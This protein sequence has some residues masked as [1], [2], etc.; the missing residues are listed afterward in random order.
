MYQMTTYISEKPLGDILRTWAGA[1]NV[2]A[3]PLVCGTR[4]RHDYEVRKNGITYSVEYNG[5]GH[6]RDPNV[7]YRDWAKEELSKNIGRKVVQLPYFIQ[8]T[9]ET[10]KIFFDDDFEI[11]TTFPHGFVATKMLP[12]S[13]CPLGYSRALADL[14]KMPQSVNTAVMDS[15][16]IKAEQLGNDLVYFRNSVVIPETGEEVSW[17]EFVK[18]ANDVHNNQYEYVRPL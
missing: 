15:L 16:K 10:F 2:T 12:S 9:T 5:D 7:I 13:F 1:E 3:Q 6:Y 8:L 14:E 4:M 18:R 17:A 11:E